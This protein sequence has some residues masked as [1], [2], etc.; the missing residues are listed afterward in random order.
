LD[1]CAP[2]AAAERGTS[3]AE[4]VAVQSPGLIP[5]TQTSCLSEHLSERTVV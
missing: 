4:D 3:V 1:S 2:G 5:G